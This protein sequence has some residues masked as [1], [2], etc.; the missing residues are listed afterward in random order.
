MSNTLANSASSRKLLLAQL[1]HC[2]CAN[3]TCFWIELALLWDCKFWNF[4]LG[5]LPSCFQLQP[6]QK[7][8]DLLARVLE[9][10]WVSITLRYLW[11]TQVLF[12]E[13]D[14][15]FHNLNPEIWRLYVH[16]FTTR[17]YANCLPSEQYMH[18]YF[19]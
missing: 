10:S 11:T 5:K 17:I 7:L 19:V 12:H 4:S 18:I 2:S 13:M 6:A 14:I 8:L 9:I 16:T 15:I 3:L 1:A